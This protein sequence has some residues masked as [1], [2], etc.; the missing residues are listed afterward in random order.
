MKNEK[1]K[2]S[3]A[4]SFKRFDKL[5]FCRKKINTFQDMITN[6][7]LAVQQ[8]KVKDIIGASELNVCIQG[9][10]S[11]YDELNTIRNVLE[12]S[13]SRTPSRTS[14]IS[15]I[16]SRTSSSSSRG[17]T[18]KKK[19]TKKKKKKTKGKKKRYDAKKICRYRK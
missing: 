1:I 14:S 7:I 11:L 6:T 2:P 9:L 4:Q 8:Y 16:R 13:G 10:E 12:S 15:S 5:D 19:P 3:S 18:K 17:S